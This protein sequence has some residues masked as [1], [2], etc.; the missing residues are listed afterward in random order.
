M[1]ALK[2]FINES[3][4]NLKQISVKKAAGFGLAK[5]N[6]VP[7]NYLLMLQLVEHLKFTRE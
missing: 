4:Y 6:L 3:F 7:E 2:D 5:S 1:P